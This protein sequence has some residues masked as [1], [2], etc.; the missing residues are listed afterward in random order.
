MSAAEAAD[1]TVAV[2]VDVT[3][4]RMD[5]P[6]ADPPR[7][8]PPDCTVVAATRCSV[9]FYRYLYDTV[10]G[11]WLWWLRRTMSDAE[12]ARLLAQPSIAIRVL[13]RHGEPAGFYELEARSD[14][15]V[16]LSYFGLM[17]WAIG[18]GLGRAFLRHAVDTAWQAGAEAVTVNTCTADHPR[19][20]PNYLLAGFRK[21]RTLREVWPIPFRLGLPIPP[22]LRASA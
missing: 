11:P 14:R 19:A 17:P 21:L 15:S 13:Y 22:H 5:S 7:L 4:L 10:G 20:L 8:L 1:T 18:Q 2:A 9:P 12:L 6:P 3:F 16:N